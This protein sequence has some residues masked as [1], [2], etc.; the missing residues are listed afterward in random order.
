MIALFIDA[1]N[2]S[3]SGWIEEAIQTI[4]QKE[5]D[6]AIRRAY[7]STENLKGLADVLRMR[8]IRPF[9]NL[10]LPKNTTDMSLAVDVME[11]VCQTPQ[12]KLLVVA[13]GDLDFVPLVVRLRERGIRVVCVTERGKMA[14]DAIPAYNQIIYVGENLVASAAMANLAIVPAVTENHRVT[15]KQA[16]TKNPVVKTS[17]PKLVVEKKAPAKKANK[18]NPDT[19]SNDITHIIITTAI[20]NLKDGKW[21]QLSEV[22][23]LLHD[24]K[25]LA[26]NATSTKLFRKF[27]EH[28]E[29]TPAVKPSQVRYIK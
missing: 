3:S 1:D 15:P 29:L 23:K 27:P 28:F 13:S 2:F 14:K 22:A 5:G 9:V 17:P 8:S 24:K 25:I 10:P 19:A 11:L 21:R 7:G 12:L 20:P 18:K 26:K 16:A 6:I 4:E